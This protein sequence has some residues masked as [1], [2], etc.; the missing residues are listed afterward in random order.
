MYICINKIG[1]HFLHIPHNECLNVIIILPT[2][3]KMGREVKPMYNKT[4][5]FIQT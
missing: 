3:L 1:I 4:N 5:H 2:K